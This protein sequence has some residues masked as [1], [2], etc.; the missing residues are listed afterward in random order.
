MEKSN[1]LFWVR[2]RWS[3]R[4]HIVLSK[5]VKVIYMLNKTWGN[6]LRYKWVYLDMWTTDLKRG[7]TTNMIR[8]KKADPPRYSLF[9]SE[10]FKN[11]F[12][13]ACGLNSLGSSISKSKKRNC[14]T[15]IALLIVKWIVNL[16]LTTILEE[17]I[18]L[19]DKQHLHDKIERFW[20][21]EKMCLNYSFI[22][23]QNYW[24]V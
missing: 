20:N 9:C 8:K 17:K 3:S 13:K 18:C 5:E 6:C 4:M 21:C 15:S 2:G 22:R 1:D 24:D 14:S 10:L 19:S 16:K 23:G 12:V 11:R 7:N